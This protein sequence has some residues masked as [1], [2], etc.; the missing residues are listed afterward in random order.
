MTLRRW[1]TDPP[2]LGRFRFAPAGPRPDPHARA[3][4][5][6]RLD[7]M[8]ARMAQHGPLTPEDPAEVRRAV[9]DR[10]RAL[11]FER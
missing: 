3:K 5:L 4:L 7:A 11:G 1:I 10:V 2:D 9:L 6:A 8:H